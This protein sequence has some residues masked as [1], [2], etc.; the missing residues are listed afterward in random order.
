MQWRSLLSVL[1]LLLFSTS[2]SAQICDDNS[3]EL[4][5]YYIQSSATIMQ[6]TQMGDDINISNYTAQG[7]VEVLSKDQQ[8]VLMRI[9]NARFDLYSHY[10]C[11][12]A[13]CTD[14]KPSASEL[15]FVDRNDSDE[16]NMTVS[17]MATGHRIMVSSLKADLS[18]SDQIGLG[19]RFDLAYRQ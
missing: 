3:C 10:E 15:Y 12:D 11:S 7:S 2:L 18:G 8:T 5:N 13:N 1:T 9:D 6:D 4:D 16:H 14:F 19:F 17:L